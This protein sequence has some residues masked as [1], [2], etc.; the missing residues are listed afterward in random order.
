MRFMS[1][2]HFPHVP[3]EESCQDSLTVSVLGLIQLLQTALALFG[4]F[5]ISKAQRNGLLCDVTVKGL[6]RW[7]VEIGEATL[8]LEA[9]AESLFGYKS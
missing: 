8:S 2:Y 4:M 1:T 6:E 7:T 9:S 3:R 5:D